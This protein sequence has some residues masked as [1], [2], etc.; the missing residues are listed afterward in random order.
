MGTPTLCYSEP[1]GWNLG[2][3]T[4]EIRQLLPQRK[5][6]TIPVTSTTPA[7][8]ASS[9]TSRGASR[10]THRRRTRSQILVNLEHRGACG[11]ETNTGDGAGILLQMPHELPR[12]SVRDRSASRCRPPGQYGVGAGLPAARRRPAARPASGCS[13]RSCATRADVPRLA[14]RADRQRDARPDRASDRSRSSARCSSA[15]APRSATD[16]AP[17]SASSTSS[18]SRARARRAPV[19]RPR[20]AP[21]FYI[22]SL[23]AQDRRLQGD[24]DCRPAAA[25]LPDLRDD[26]RRVG[27]GAGPLALLDQHLPQ[28]GARPP[29]PADRPQ[30]RD[31]HA[32]RQRQ[33][34]ARAREHV[35]VAACSATT[36]RSAPGHRHRRQRLG[37]V[38]QRARA[39]GARRAVAAARDDDDDPRAVAEPRVDERRSART[40]TSTTAA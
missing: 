38:R 23:S 5:A 10:R 25:V 16:D 13:S 4:H 35:Q 28:L 22:P 12:S 11:C 3:L 30:R 29:L 40:S 7:A 18:A 15:A 2:S 36:S 32:A 31:Q 14:R 27:A 39:A 17:S 6:S 21:D 19:G 24:A 1:F 20:A 34:D 26:R 9:S 33:L 8:S 37:D